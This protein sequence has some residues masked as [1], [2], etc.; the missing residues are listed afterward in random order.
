MKMKL[1]GILL[2]VGIVPAF[3]QGRGGARDP[4]VVEQ[5]EATEKELES[6]AII[7]RKVMIPMRDGKQDRKSVV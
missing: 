2:L 7:E 3:P 5:R 1:L 4:K 6:L